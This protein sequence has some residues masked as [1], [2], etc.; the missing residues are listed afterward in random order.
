MVNVEKIMKYE[1]GGMNTREIVEMFAELIKDG[2]A[3][4]LQGSIYGRPAAKFIENGYITR[5]G[6]ITEKG[7]QLIENATIAEEEV[8]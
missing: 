8:L 4:Q 5:T 2:S 3:W 1:D 6:E 7:Q